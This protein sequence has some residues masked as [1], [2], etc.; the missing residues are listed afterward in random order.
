MCVCVS[1]KAPSVVERV[2]G[3]LISPSCWFD[4]LGAADQIKEAATEAPPAFHKQ[5]ERKGM[6]ER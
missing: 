4:P 1:E 3:A 2:F 5:A 6:N